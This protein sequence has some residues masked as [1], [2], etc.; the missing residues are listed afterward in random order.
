MQVEF[1]CSVCETPLSTGYAVS[2]PGSVRVYVYKC[3]KC[4]AQT[5]ESTSMQRFKDDMNRLWIGLT[6]QEL[7][8]PTTGDKCHGEAPSQDLHGVSHHTA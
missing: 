6:G 3:E 8:P 4:H 5:V 1:L 2:P 7:F